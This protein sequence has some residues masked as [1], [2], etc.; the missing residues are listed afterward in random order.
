MELRCV[1]LDFRARGRFFLQGRVE[2][3]ECGTA[4]GV[5]AE[6]FVQFVVWELRR[7]L[8]IGRSHTWA[9]PSPAGGFLLHVEKRGPLSAGANL[10]SVQWE[11][12]VVRVRE[13]AAVCSGGEL[14][15]LRIDE[16]SFGCELR[17]APVGKR[18]AAPG[19]APLP[20]A[21]DVVTANG[22]TSPLAADSVTV[23]KAENVGVVRLSRPVVSEGGRLSG[24][25]EVAYVESLGIRNPIRTTG[26]G[27]VAKVY[28]QD[29][30][31]VDFGQPLFAIEYV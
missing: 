28:V 1:V 26:S 2:V 7:Y 11:E 14:V 13:A 3:F 16:R 19:P 22:A 21:A 5:V 24:V 4:F 9:L 17:R 20:H 29:G 18:A 12:V 15:R 27:T 25:R 6:R 30:Q 31:P 23:L 10:R 8:G